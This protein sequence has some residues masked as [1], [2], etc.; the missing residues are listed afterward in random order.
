MKRGGKRLTTSKKSPDDGGIPDDEPKSFL[1][2]L[3]DLRDTVIWSAVSIVVG[4]L[5]AIPFTPWVIKIIQRP[6]SQVNGINADTFLITL[7]PSGTFMIIMKASVWTGVL[8]SFPVVLFIIGSFIIPGLT[9]KERKLVRITL[10][11]SAVLFVVGVLMG[12]KW[13]VP[14]ALQ[15]MLWFPSWIGVNCPGWMLGDYV[16]FVLRL[17]V[18]FGIVFEL[19]V[20]VYVLGALGIINSDQMRFYRR[21]VIVGLLVLGAILTPPDPGTQI[22]MAMPLVILYEISIWLVKF[23]E[24]SKTTEDD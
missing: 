2:H 19:P 21:H 20:V 1:E 22:M 16:V 13:T 4:I 3:E 18:A 9:F 14:V 7:D 6:L 5:I 15:V 8:L 11:V 17:L 23:R 10:S 24:T 12:Y